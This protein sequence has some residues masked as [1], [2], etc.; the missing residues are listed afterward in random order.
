MMKLSKELQ[1]FSEATRAQD[2]HWIQKAKLDF[3]L[4]LEFQ[5]HLSGMTYSAIAEKIGTSKAYITKVFRG[6]ANL[7]I[8]SMVK[9][10]RASGGR[11]D[12]RIVDEQSHA[13][14]WIRT[15]AAL[16]VDTSK[17]PIRTDNVVMMSE[18]ANRNI[19]A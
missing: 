4:A 3:S 6:D 8:E 17:Q 12:I 2:I 11:V 18:Y 1:K 5:R 10:A 14:R 13:S 16:P 7:T 15:I 19:A 9:L